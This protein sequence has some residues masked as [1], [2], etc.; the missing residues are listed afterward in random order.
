MVVM[1]WIV[2]LFGFYAGG[3]GAIHVLTGWS[4]WVSL[5]LFVVCYFGSVFLWEVIQA[6]LTPSPVAKRVRTVQDRTPEIVEAE[7][8]LATAKGHVERASET[9]QVARS[10]AA[11]VF[12]TAA[13]ARDAGKAEE[14]AEKALQRAAAT[15]QQAEAELQRKQEQAGR[16][17]HDYVLRRHHPE[18]Q[19]AHR[20]QTGSES[21]WGWTSAGSE[22]RGRDLTGEIGKAVVK[23]QIATARAINQDRKAERAGRT[24]LGFLPSPEQLSA[25]WAERDA[26]KAQQ[27]IESLREEQRRR[28]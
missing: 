8:N 9:L 6:A 18:V 10:T 12:N 17:V 7:R 1:W 19:Q 13:A 22:V 21:R 3:A 26:G 5:V 25:F 28:K 11:G 2:I 24:F 16:E 15:H 23:A 20:S 27:R 4:I 14:A